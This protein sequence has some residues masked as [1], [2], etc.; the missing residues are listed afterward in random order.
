M[1]ATSKAEQGLVYE[2][3]AF[4]LDVH[5][6][7][8]LRGATHVALTPKAFELLVVLVGRRGRLVTKEELFQEVWA[9]SFV[10]EGNLTQNIYTLRKT[11]GEGAGEQ[12][13]IETVPKQ[14][15]RFVAPV[16]VV[17]HEAPPDPH[18]EAAG[19]E[20]T[21]AHAAVD[22]G[23]LPARH[24]DEHVQTTS[25]EL[26]VEPAQNLIHLSLTDP[27][28]RAFATSDAARPAHRTHASTPRRRTWPYALTA[29]LVFAACA[30]AALGM[31]RWRTAQV[32]PAPAIRS[33][34]VLPFKPLGAE[35]QDELL[36]LGMADATI[37]KLSKLPQLS[38]LPTSAI[39][40]FTDRE[41]EPLVIGR[42]LGVDAVLDGTVQHAGERVRVTVQLLRLSD[43]RTLWAGKFDEQFTDIFTVQDSISA[44][45]AQVLAPQLTGADKEHLTKRYT[46]NT[47]AYEAY[48]RGLYFWNKRSEDG[49]RRSIEYFS[50]AI[51]LDPNYALA[52]AGLA[53]SYALVGFYGYDQ[54]MPM[55]ESY[56]RARAAA[57]RA[58]ALDGSL[59]EA[60]TALAQLKVYY[61]R[62]YDE[63][64]RALQRAITL[65]PNYATA[66]Q[67]YS[68]LLLERGR[69]GEAAQEIMRAHELDP[70]SAVINYNTGR[71][72]YLQR[73]YDDAAAYCR[74]ALETDP[75]LPQPLITLAL[76]AQQQG[77]ADEAVAQ[78][79]K[80]KTQTTAAGY[81][82]VLEALG[83][84]YAAAGRQTDA[85]RVVTELETLAR[86]NDGIL[87]SLALVHAQL[88]NLDRAFALLEERAAHW[89]VPPF[90]LLFDPRFDQLRA[91][92]RYT[93]FLQRHKFNQQ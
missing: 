66:H 33:I 84:A 44:Q 70:L 68:I 11:L 48:V 7:L 16:R 2:F 14:G 17:T 52:H 50:E 20:D 12:T 91:D 63:A 67:R 86:D 49:L 61:E 58:L 93:E 81:S 41:H 89:Q 64:E 80:L 36:G 88:G 31:W 19:H 26:A 8:L 4:R 75:S 71:V 82:T 62:N 53:D 24:Y 10:E 47:E 40:K 34:A 18:I 32:R 74:K 28:A 46:N 1:P 59:A 9:G 22:T 45:V 77:R 73:H 6:R 15:Y 57:L 54:I 51:R 25:D 83:C 78:L 39:Y 35:S 21:H 43:G 69:L 72:H 23:E 29:L 30:F 5:E 37:I 3:G 55:R 85:Q 13:F 65:N 38:V 87:F 56:E 42:E 92:P 79:E 90:P 27:H 60:H 76:I